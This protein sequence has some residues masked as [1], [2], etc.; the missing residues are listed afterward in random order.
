MAPYYWTL[1]GKAFV[2]LYP[3]DC[4]KLAEKMLEY[5]GEAGT[6]L[7]EFRSK[8]RSVLAEIARRKPVDI[9]RQIAVYLGPNRKFLRARLLTDC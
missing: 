6:I 1:I 4:M 2:E 8:T 5:F 7:G 9:W 3:S